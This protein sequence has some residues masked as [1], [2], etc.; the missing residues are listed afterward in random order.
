MQSAEDDN[1]TT[2]ISL[3]VEESNKLRASLGLPLLETENMQDESI[4]NFEKYKKSQHHSEKRQKLAKQIEK[5]RN[6]KSKQ[7]MHGVTLG[8]GGDSVDDPLK[9]IR[10]MKPITTPQQHK[11]EEKRHYTSDD[12]AGMKVVHDLN[13]VADAGTEVILTLKDATIEELEESGDLLENVHIAD[14]DRKKKALLESGRKYNALDDTMKKTTILS[15]YDELEEEIG[16]Q[17]QNQGAILP[18]TNNKINMS[19]DLK[20]ASV[21]LEATSKPRREIS[22]YYTAEELVSFK[23]P[24]KNK[25]K[26]SK[27]RKIRQ[28]NHD[29]TDEEALQEKPLFNN[30]QRSFNTPKFQYSNKNTDI[31]DKPINFV[32]DEDLQLSLQ[33]SRQ[34]MQKKKINSL[35]AIELK[36]SSSSSE[37]EHGGI[38]ISDTAEFVRNLDAT[39]HYLKTIEKS[40]RDSINIAESESSED[41]NMDDR[42]NDKNAIDVEM[43]DVESSGK[44]NNEIEQIDIT[45]II[46]DDEP[47]V[48]RGL[49][50]ALSLLT[51]QGVLKKPPN[52]SETEKGRIRSINNLAQSERFKWLAEQK[53][54]EIQDQIDMNYKRQKNKELGEDG[55]KRSQYQHSAKKDR[56]EILRAQIQASQD[57]FKNYVPD[58][59]LEYKDDSG[60]HLTPKEVKTTSNDRHSG[61]SHKRSTA[62]NQEKI[63]WKNAY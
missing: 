6:S 46:H 51:K 17:I 62:R 43:K 24:K 37:S 55:K 30:Q 3:S 25:K 53:K 50:A 54:K 12:L 10:A 1:K 23:K 21:S 26:S 8:E 39:S 52:P 41:E 57:K 35:N 29:D 56:E 34:Q 60:R 44:T 63:R 61:S 45:K 20:K 59:K 42:H 4:E 5:E 36:D 32:D 28:K 38:I 15:H 47:L 58:V 31:L 19:E 48:S 40:G 18:K 9:W 7:K 13:D 27:T 33:I 22:D 11:E 49:G 16:F 2:E 14:S